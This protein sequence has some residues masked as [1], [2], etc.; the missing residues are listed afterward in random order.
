ML[1][2]MLICIVLIILWYVFPLAKVC[3]R[4]MFP[5]YKDGGVLL[6][7]RLFKNIKT[8]KVYVYTRTNEEGEKILVVKRLTK[9]RTYQTSPK[10]LKTQ[11]FFEGDNPTESY[12]SRDYGYI[13]AENIIARVLW[14]IK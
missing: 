12:D 10:E 4:S 14:K 8:G 5:T 6:T 3:G 7:T 1:K 13:N 9:I 2:L 11:C